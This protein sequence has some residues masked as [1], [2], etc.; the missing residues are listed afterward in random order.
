MMESLAS[1]RGRR[2]AK[3][4]GKAD[5]NRIQQRTPSV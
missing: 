1:I 5:P 2:I 3:D 4:Y